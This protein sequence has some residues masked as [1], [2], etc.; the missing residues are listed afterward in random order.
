MDKKCDTFLDAN[1]LTKYEHINFLYNKFNLIERTLFIIIICLRARRQ[2]MAYDNL[3]SL[4][5]VILPKVI[6]LFEKNNIF[7][8][9]YFKGPVFFSR[10]ETFLCY[11][12]EI[13]LSTC[14]YVNKTHDGH[15]VKF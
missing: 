13:N 14:I 6:E 8:K 5:Y 9:I 4:C 1:I 12:T 3:E 10:G 7:K 11:T 15:C 2:G